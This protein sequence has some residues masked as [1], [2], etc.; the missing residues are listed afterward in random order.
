M[1]MYRL[2]FVGFALLALTLMLGCSGQTN[3]RGE[4]TGRSV[5]RDM[6]PE[7]Q[8][9]GE[10]YEVRHNRIARSISETWRQI[11]DD[12]DELWLVDEPSHLS[13]YPI[14]SSR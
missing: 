3:V 4:Y 12:W 5:R 13:Q 6:A 7:L 11:Y 1:N 14:P 9:P 10:T 2:V 8:T